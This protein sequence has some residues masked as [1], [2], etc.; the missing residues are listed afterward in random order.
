M[1]FFLTVDGPG[2]AWSLR[3]PGHVHVFCTQREL[4]A[5]EQ[6]FIS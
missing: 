2:S 5:S 1:R 4:K 3:P 6:G